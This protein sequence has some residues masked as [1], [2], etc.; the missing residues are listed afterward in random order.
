MP[1]ETSAVSGRMAPVDLRSFERERLGWLARR[2]GRELTGRHMVDRTGQPPSWQTESAAGLLQGS[3]H[4]TW[5]PPSLGQQ[6]DP[7][8]TAQGGL[9]GESTQL[10]ETCA[11][12][13]FE[14]SR[15]VTTT[16]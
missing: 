14:E 11:D 15:P 5:T 12:C 4:R 1:R 13:Y 9:A 2:R 3:R 8:R 7:P 6:P 10:G 16:Q